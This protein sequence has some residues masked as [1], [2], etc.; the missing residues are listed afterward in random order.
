MSDV[1]HNESS[2]KAVKIPRDWLYG[3]EVPETTVTIADDGAVTWDGKQI[4]Y[5]WKGE[6]TYSPPIIKGSRIVRYHKRVPEWQG[7]LSGRRY[8]RDVYHCDTRQAVIQRLIADAEREITDL[9][10]TLT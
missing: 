2:G 5:V 7:S 8:G 10:R 6:R 4:G 3:G 1:G 9:R